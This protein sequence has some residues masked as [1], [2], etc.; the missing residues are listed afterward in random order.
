MNLTITVPEGSSNHGNPN[1]LCTPT[2]WFDYLLFFFSNYFAH[3]ATVVASPGQGRRETIFVVLAALLL[4]GSGVLRAVR[5]I[6]RHSMTESDPL[7]RAIR[8]GALCMVVR[9][10]RSEPGENVDPQTLEAGHAGVLQV[11]EEQPHT[12]DSAKLE[13]TD[14][15]AKGDGSAGCGAEEPEEE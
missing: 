7:K 10:G 11:A 14:Q 6:Y 4:P 3:A 2:R 5:A 15:S 1:L 8:A 12:K 9:S 13:S